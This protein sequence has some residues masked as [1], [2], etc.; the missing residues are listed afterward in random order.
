MQTQFSSNKSKEMHI[1]IKVLVE[2]KDKIS[3][4]KKWTLLMFAFQINDA[5][6]NFFFYDT[7]PRIVLPFLFYT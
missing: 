7:T 3:I 4:E 5:N 2:E 6:V 1:K